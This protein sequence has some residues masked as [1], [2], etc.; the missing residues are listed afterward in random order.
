VDVVGATGQ[1]WAVAAD[2]GF[3]GLVEAAVVGIGGGETLARCCH[4]VA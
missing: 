2:D 3:E 1:T 4:T